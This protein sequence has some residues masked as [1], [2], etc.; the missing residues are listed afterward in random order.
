MAQHQFDLSINTVSVAT[1]SSTAYGPL[2][3]TIWATPSRTLTQGAYDQITNQIW[4]TDSR[5][6]ATAGMNA[7]AD[8]VWRRTYAN[9]RASANGDT[10]NQRSGLGAQ[11]K[12]V[13]QVTVSGSTLQIM[14]EDDTTVFLSQ[15][16]ATNSTAAPI[17]SLDTV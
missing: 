13:N 10:L 8:H 2:V 11:A 12:L 17:T 5:S 1:I 15:T 16:I 3:N 7:V 9:I 14:H 6:L 4:A